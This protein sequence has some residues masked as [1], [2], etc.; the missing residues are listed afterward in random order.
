MKVKITEFLK[1]GSGQSFLFMAV[2]TKQWHQRHGV[3]LFS[4]WPGNSPDLNP[5]ESLWSQMKQMQ[6]GER[7]TSMAELKKIALIVWRK[8]TPHCA[9]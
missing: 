2:K 3:K 1:R 5:I 8:I 7:A 6:I 9:M 4:G